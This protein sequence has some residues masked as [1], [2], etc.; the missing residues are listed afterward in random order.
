MTDRSLR[1]LPLL[2]LLPLLFC[3]AAAAAADD[4][5]LLLQDP[6]ISHG[7]VVF[8]YADDL[9][10]VGAEGGDARRLTSSPG[11]EWAPRLSP[12]GKWLAFTGQ[13]EG[14]TDVYLMPVAGGAPRRLT[15]H[16]GSDTVLA[17][18][19]DGKGIIF[20]SSRAS[21][22][23]VA[24]A[25]V[26]DLEGHM[27]E[28]LEL[29][30]VSHLSVDAKGK[31]F[32]YT[33]VWD[34]F[35][36]WKRYR[37]GR[38]VPV[39]I[40]DRKT[41]AVE[42][43]PH[44]NAS[45]T[46]PCWVGEAVYFAS[47]R[48]GVMN[49][50]R[51]RPGER[52]VEQITRYDDYHVRSL[53]SDGES[54]VFEQ[55]GRLHVYDPKTKKVRDL[56]VVVRADGLTALPR[57][58]EAR[59]SVR[60]AGISPNGKRAV[61]EAR[62]EIVTLPREHGDVR[63]LSDSP[64]AHDRDPVW[65]PDGKQVAWFSDA[66][67]EYELVVRDRLGRGEAKSYDLKGGGF[68]HR[69]QWSPDGERILFYDKSN[70]IA[71]LTLEGG[72]VTTV[73]RV[74]GSLGVVHPDVAWSADSKWIAYTDRNERT[75]YDRIA[76]FELASGETTRLTDDF[77][78]SGNPAFSPDGKYLYFTASINQGPLMMGLNMGTSAS[79]GWD[80]S[81]YVAV[82]QADEENPLF[83]KSD[84]A[85]VD[86]DEGSGDDDK[87][88]DKK[89]KD[90]DK[91]SKDGDKK[92]KGG[93]EKSKGGDTKS[94]GDS[95]GKEDAGEEADGDEKELPAVDLKNLDQRI[96]SL[97][98]DEGRY[99]NLRCA[100]EKLLF[101]EETPNGDHRLMAFDFDEREAKELK[102]EVDFFA[103]AGDGKSLLVQSGESW[104]ITDADA[105][106]DKSLAVAAV[107]LR[108]EPELEW[109]Q[110]LREVWRI[111]R[112]YFY[113]PNMHGVDWD[114]MWT[115]WERFLPH[116]KHRSELTLL[117][118]ELIG[119]LSCGHEYV[120]GGDFPDGPEGVTVGLLGADF[121]LD[122]GRYRIE[123]ILRGQNWNPGSRAPLTEPGVD[124][125][126]GDYLIAVNGREIRAGENLYRAF[127]NT[128]G[129][130][131]DLTLSAGSDGK[132]PRTVSAVPLSGE[133]DLRFKSWI[134]SNR[135][136]VDELSGGRL[137]YVYMRDTGGAGRREF[138]RDFYS[139]LDR[140]GLILDERY[141]GGGQV[142]DYVIEVLSRDVMSY[143]MNRELWLS[144]SPAGVMEGPKVMIANESAGS[145]G[146]WMPWAFQRAG[147]GPLVGTRTWGGLVGISG[148]PPLMDGGAVTAASFG[149]MDTDGEWAVENVGVAPDYEVIEYP[150]A[151]IAGGDPQLEKAVQLALDALAQAP[152]Q[153]LPTYHPP[154]KR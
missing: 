37:G 147:L 29:P 4:E 55:A 10:I 18:Q 21:N 2:I 39:W 63:N 47:D 93:D 145:G 144:R 15:W 104:S 112:D 107:K 6:A 41:Q 138:D 64:G 24:E 19:P 133:W 1:A 5:T 116:V 131:I 126:E 150:K 67:G 130:Q 121:V 11:A 40:F 97:P 76:L 38:T 106:D 59:G 61:F 95:G 60:A 28:K 115:R 32:A 26:V 8:R 141:N 52:E 127:E 80:G 68:F 22:S 139:Q 17:W 128:A 108:V 111:E 109:P 89:G 136:R 86:E 101:I 78:V 114:R 45:D 103:V 94:K 54:V 44:V 70:R 74:Q 36:S 73:A 27:P 69:P 102:A 110:I 123:R 140:E 91:K 58:Q 124:A 62:G 119:E 16:P 83:P 56:R 34:A 3:C 65:S 71:Y 125:N 134:E 120:W 113:D 142:A 23:R 143:W 31:R 92:S 84:D 53:S 50:Y 88:G 90:G 25:F 149:V 30:K 99:S 152:K 82:L 81:V 87:D 118:R 79:R 105:G 72:E 9:W 20:R 117:I 48:D 137:A 57:W 33:P 75:L 13:Y 12:D 14:N 148:Y 98:V 46:W 77:A 96:L 154:A 135:R 42:V 66:S 7:Q 151:I 122:G 129:K 51:F 85:E 100:G 35:G 132:E 49:L 43:V 146:D 153:K